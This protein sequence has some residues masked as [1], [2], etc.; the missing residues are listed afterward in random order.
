M[1]ETHSSVQY[2]EHT[3]DKGTNLRF[4]QSDN[5]GAWH[6]LTV[7]TGSSGSLLAKNEATTGGQYYTV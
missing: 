6:A 4:Y 1:Y 2:L 3:E 7:T 5:S